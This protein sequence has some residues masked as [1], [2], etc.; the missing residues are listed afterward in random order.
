MA[1]NAALD[2]FLTAPLIQAFD[3]AIVRRGIPWT[4]W[5][6]LL[7]VGPEKPAGNQF[8]WK[9]FKG[10]RKGARFVN[11]GSPGIAVETPGSEFDS[12]TTWS[13]RENYLFDPQE[14]M[15]L[16]AA[17][18]IVQDRVRREHLKRL[19]D[20]KEKLLTT[21]KNLVASAYLTGKVL[22]CHTPQG[23]IIVNSTASTYNGVSPTSVTFG[24]QS[25]KVGDT[26]PGTSST[27]PDFSTSTTDIPKFFRE[28]TKGFVR[29][30]NYM[31]K[32]IAYG[33]NIPGYMGETNASMQAYWSRNQA[34]G[35]AYQSTGEIPTM[36]LGYDWKR[37]YLQYFI[38]ESNAT[39]DTTATWLDADTLIITPEFDNGWYEA[40]EGGQMVP[41]GIL[42][43]PNGDAVAQ[44]GQ[45]ARWGMYNYAYP[46]VVTGNIIEVAGDNFGAFIK[47]GSAHWIIKVH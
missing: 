3:T 47:N 14:R 30:T 32:K 11:Y 33:E 17:P 2:F 36:S 46:D 19:A 24:S 5:D 29:T 4:L 16:I 13:A 35:N 23:G 6:E 31:P 25:L 44:S 18:S 26:I 21:R 39:A 1:G 34:Y 45:I 15:M 37:G 28:V 12:G 8:I 20:R 43:G 10:E 7:E 27:V 42:L 22:V 40:I 9:K 38:D 41:T